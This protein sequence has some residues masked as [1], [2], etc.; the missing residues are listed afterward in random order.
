MY[1]LVIDYFNRF[2]TVHEW[3]DSSNSRAIVKILEKL[4]ST[5]GVPNTIVSD[6]E[7]QFVSEE[8]RSFL[9]RWNIQH[10]TSSPQ[11]PQS[12]RE[13][14]RVVRTVKGLMDKNINLHAVLC[15]YRDI[16]LA[17]GYSPAQLSFGRSLKLM[18]N[19]SV[20]GI[21]LNKLRNYFQ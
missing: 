5:L 21:N 10:V 18:G 6:N 12:N 1:L 9:G 20:G 11:F 2:I 7:P 17:N 16:P 14:E 15:M 4:F 8:V 13:A 3:K 19:M